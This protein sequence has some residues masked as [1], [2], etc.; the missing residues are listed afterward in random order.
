MSIS[1]SPRDRQSGSRSLPFTQ[2]QRVPA[3]SYVPNSN[4]Y[5]SHP[6]K[7]FCTLNFRIS[8]TETHLVPIEGPRNRFQEIRND[9]AD[10][11]SYG[12]SE[13][14]RPERFPGSLQQVEKATSGAESSNATTIYDQGCEG[15][16]SY[17]PF[18]AAIVDEASERIS[19]EDRPASKSLPFLG[20]NAQQSLK[21]DCSRDLTPRQ[22]PS[23]NSH[24]TAGKGEIIQTIDEDSPLLS[25]PVDY[26]IN[27]IHYHSSPQ[28]LE[29][30][31]QDPIRRPLASRR[32][33]F[34]SFRNLGKL[35]NWFKDCRQVSKDSPKRW[36]TATL[37]AFAPLIIG[38]LMNILDAL[39][40][41]RIM[42]P[43][44][45]PIFADLAPVGI[46]MF[47]V[48]TIISQ[49][50]YSLG[51][52]GFQAGVGSEMIEV[53]PFFHQMAFKILSEVGREKPDVVRSTT[54]IAFI[55]SS[56]ITGITFLLM[57]RFR[58]GELIGFFPHHVLTGCIGGIG[59]FLL[60]TGLD[61]SARLD[62]DLHPD[63]G[64]IG[65]L[66]AKDTLPRWLIPL[67]LML[68]LFLIKWWC[69]SAFVDASFYCG[70]LLVFHVTV[71]AIPNEQLEDLQRS[72]WVFQGPQIDMPWY[73]LYSLYSKLSSTSH[74][75]NY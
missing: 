58:L 15:H 8:P 50:V 43:L 57:S 75:C 21:D 54:F 11:A 64:T 22:P 74:C 19:G 55:M 66:F 20:F 62:G 46:S 12:R 2:P 17:R 9:T 65:K 24:S 3:R 56:V 49:L 53:I 52:S 41:G 23:D 10:L 37:R 35:G 51:S 60:Q 1:T 28:D 16:E 29:N 73:S 13:T 7:S 34:L 42:F 72:G 26:G 68:T 6:S 38:L 36:V 61:V 67:A 44:A 18:S 27:D 70:L 30:Q 31:R 63:L 40:Y 59:L 71:A 25:K 48:S 47:Y 69:H 4:S 32:K 45:E 14:D 39:S 33:A 5:Q